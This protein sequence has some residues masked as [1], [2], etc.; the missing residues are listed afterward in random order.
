M[1]HLRI[2]APEEWLREDFK[3]ATGFDV[4]QLLD[5]L[6]QVVSKIRMENPAVAARREQGLDPGDL[7]ETVPF[8][9]LSNLKHAIVPVH[10]AH[11][12]SDP[13]KRFL[14]I[15]MSAGNDTPG[16]T[17]AVRRRVAQTLG[18]EADAFIGNLQGLASVTVHVKDIDRDRGYST[19][20][21]R[22]KKRESAAAAKPA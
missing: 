10:Y 1:P 2:E 4:K 5:H 16:R 9:N 17:A 8:I 7:P 11:V 3:A 15:T 6:V 14:H 20:A 18:D 12:A 19:T 13:A 21:E 22:R